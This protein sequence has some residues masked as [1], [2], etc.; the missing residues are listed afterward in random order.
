MIDVII[1]VLVF[2]LAT[3]V[4]LAAL[5]IGVGLSLL[6]T[7]WIWLGVESVWSAIF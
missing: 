4:I 7:G 3:I 6:F 2:V 1:D 5:L